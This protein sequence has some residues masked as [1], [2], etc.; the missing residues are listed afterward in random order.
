MREIRM[1]YDARR[2]HAPAWR[3]VSPRRHDE[4]ECWMCRVGGWSFALG[5]GMLLIALAARIAE[6]MARAQGWHQAT[7]LACGGAL[8]VIVWVCIVAWQH[9]RG[10]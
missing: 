1:R 4:R 3:V 10:R 5:A 7:A 8:G 9:D 2:E 6:A